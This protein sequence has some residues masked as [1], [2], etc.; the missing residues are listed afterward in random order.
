MCR[1]KDKEYLLQEKKI[2]EKRI[3][4]LGIELQELREDSLVV[5]NAD[6]GRIG[7]DIER[8][9]ATRER[10]IKKLEGINFS[11][12]NISPKVRCEDCG[13]LIPEKRM[14]KQPDARCCTPC[15][16]IRDL[17]GKTGALRPAYSL[18][19]R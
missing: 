4:S 8:I 2:T 12:S 13:H 3:K 10:E 16:S 14:K 19:P 9:N 1:T 7:E 11:L 6:R 17:K 15:Q 18:S 5:D